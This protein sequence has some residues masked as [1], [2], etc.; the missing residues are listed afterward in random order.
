MYKGVVYLLCFSG[1]KYGLGN[2]IISRRPEETMIRA[3]YSL[4]KETNKSLS[5]NLHLLFL[6]LEIK[7]LFQ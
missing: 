6:A 7:A 2:R 3:T 5:A 1:C 4:I